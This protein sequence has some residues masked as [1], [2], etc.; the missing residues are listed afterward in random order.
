MRSIITLLVRTLM[1]ILAA[2]TFAIAVGIEGK[3]HGTSI[4]TIRDSP[5]H[6][7][8]VV[9][10]VSKPDSSGRHKIQMDKIVNGQRELMGTLDCVYDQTASVTVCDM[11]KGVWRFTVTNTK[12][13]GTLTLADGRLYRN[14][15][16]SRD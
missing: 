13:V 10:V 2:F 4:C 16:V 11:Q 12:M 5:C 14:I 9:Y 1:I 6:D 3:W 8:Q 15:S 7:E